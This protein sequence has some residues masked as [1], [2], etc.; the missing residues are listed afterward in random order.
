MRTRLAAALALSTVALLPTLPT[1][2]AATSPP[3]RFSH[4]QYDSPGT[5]SGSNSS[6]NAEWVKVTNYSSHAR[7]L[8]GWTIR[9]T[10]SHV[11]RFPTYTLRPGT[12]VRL[13][14]GRGTN[15]RT[16]LYWHQSNYVWNNTGDKAILKTR[17]GSIVDTCSWRDGPG[18]T[19]C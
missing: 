14:T 9:D 5:D 3:V 1:A 15:S 17:A 7:T 2:N 12:S 19:S 8:T 18:S 10:S 11:Y 13:H 6:L 4:V 16:D